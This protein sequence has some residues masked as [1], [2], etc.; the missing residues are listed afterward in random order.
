M[1]CHKIKK[2]INHSIDG[3]LGH[4]EMNEL[5]RHLEGCQDC[6]SFYHDVHM[7]CTTAPKLNQQ[8]PDKDLWPGIQKGITRVKPDSKFRLMAR[9]KIPFLI[10]TPIVMSML[11]MFFIISSGLY[12]LNNL[13]NSN[14]PHDYKSQMRE[15]YHLEEVLYLSVIRELDASRQYVRQATNL[16]VSQVFHE[17]LEII[18]SSIQECRESLAG[19]PDNL[20]ARKFLVKA[21]RNKVDLLTREIQISGT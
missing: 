12:Y 16:D 3:E 18:E 5:K 17:N 21:Y 11:F 6:Q 14:M 13:G 7:I 19:E 2:M 9:W 1:T 8:K 20:M 10:P 15:R 4:L